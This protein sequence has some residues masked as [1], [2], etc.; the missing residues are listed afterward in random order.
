[1]NNDSNTGVLELEDEF[2]SAMV[3]DWPSPSTSPSADANHRQSAYRIVTIA[4]TISIVGLLAA[5]AWPLLTGQIYTADD[6]GWFH[7]PMRSFYS[8]QLARG[9]S[10]DWCPNLYCGFYLTGEGQVGSYHPLHWLLYRT[11]PLSVAFNLESWLSYPL[12]LAGTYFLLRRWKLRRQAAAFGALV[13]TFGSFNLLHLIHLNGV[14][15]VAHL[16]W[17]L[18]TIDVMLR[19]SDSPNHENEIKT[20]R[21]L[22]FCGVSLFTGSQLLLG[23]PQYVMFSLAVEAG[24][25]L[26][27]ANLGRASLKSTVSALCRWLLAAGIGVLIGAV[28]WLPTLDA[29]QHSV[30]QTNAA[31]DFATQGS[32]PLLNLMQLV[33]P[34]LFANRVVGGITHEFGLY[35][36]V[37][38]L[39]LAVWWVFGAQRRGG[40]NQQALH[41]KQFRT[42][43]VA[44]LVTAGLSLLWM[45]GELGPLGW[46]QEHLPLVNKFR[47]PCRA[48][49]IFELA[50]AVLA[51]LGFADLIQPQRREVDRRPNPATSQPA[52]DRSQLLWIL[53]LASAIFTLIAMGYWLPYLGPFPLVALGPVMI[54]VA[55]GLVLRA[56]AGARWAV[57]ALVVFTALDLG[58]YGLSYSVFGH[59]ESLASFISKV[60]VP[61]GLPPQR[62]ALDLASGS[63]AAPGQKIVRIGDQITLKNWN[64]VD[65]YAG[66]DPAKQLDYHN[67]AAL[68]A[69]GVTWLDTDAVA[70][71]S[72][73]GHA[74][75]LAKRESRIMVPSE[76]V[77]SMS[78]STMWFR[79]GDPQPRAWLVT[80]TV[81]SEKPAADIAKISLATE[82][83]VDKNT[84]TLDP[85]NQP[86]DL[87]PVPE[88][89][90]SNPSGTVTITSDRPGKI[91]LS[92]NCLDEAIPGR[93]RKLSPRLAGH[94][95]S[96]NHP[97]ISGKRR[98]Y[99]TFRQPRRT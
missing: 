48:I 42:L 84:A 32:L 22:A 87:T 52:V 20:K 17:I 80:R 74:G 29:L 86:S 44:A 95:G 98:F 47:L 33:A 93:R 97:Y 35:I 65:G 19:P 34:Y 50:L 92:A 79:L 8:Q 75:W 61:P 83:L 56:V 40:Y 99:R 66:L 43:T 91:S 1:M 6:L 38:P 27:V 53:P 15:I 57:A 24:Y 16:P 31:A 70:Q 78:G 55:V 63:E 76:P 90:Q 23:Y 67:P 49:V 9:E 51:A 68:R 25:A 10:F 89:A 36:G 13:F 82:A 73:S 58:A 39:V 69:A 94:C 77:V 18:W 54:A 7:L 62:V 96:S 64:R 45:M 30:R 14:A 5:L 88:R 28:Q 72:S 81:L 85:T 60:D 59:T 46:L 37:V 3:A 71:L 2:S 26:L 12:M 21:R 11:L 41:R 4:L